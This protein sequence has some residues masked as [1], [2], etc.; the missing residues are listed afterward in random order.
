MKDCSCF[1]V[2][3]GR[4]KKPKEATEGLSNSETANHELSARE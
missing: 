3:E 2:V 1:F 4:K